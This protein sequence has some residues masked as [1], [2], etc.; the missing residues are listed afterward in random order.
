MPSFFL[1]RVQFVGEVGDGH[2]D[3]AA[4]GEGGGAGEVG[5]PL[6]LDRL[7]VEDLAGE[8]G[9]GPDDEVWGWGGGRGLAREFGEAREVAEALL[10]LPVHFV[11]LGDVGLHDGDAEFAGRAWRDGRQLGEG[12]AAGQ[13]PDG[14]QCRA[15]AA[16]PHQE[17]VGSGGGG[18]GDEERGE[19]RP[20]KGGGGGE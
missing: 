19:V 8:H 7:G 3:L 17:Q 13:G 20:Q 11:V 2:L 9:L 12:Q 1:E 5:P 18:Y 4:V 16:G 15:G 10:D 14:D 6:S